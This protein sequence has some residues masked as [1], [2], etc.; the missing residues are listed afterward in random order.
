VRL[1]TE[2]VFLHETILHT[3]VLFHLRLQPHRRSNSRRT[4]TLP[5][6][7]HRRISP[8]T[9]LRNLHSPHHSN[10]PSRLA[11]VYLHRLSSP[12]KHPIPLLLHLHL[13]PTHMQISQPCSILPGRQRHSTDIIIH[14]TISN[15]RLSH[16]KTHTVACPLHPRSQIIIPIH[17][18]GLEG[19]HPHLLVIFMDN[20]DMGSRGHNFESSKSFW[21]WTVVYVYSLIKNWLS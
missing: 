3:Q 8:R 18:N 13:H 9:P 20:Q 21:S 19:S 6:T 1:S 14:I 7:E 5:R 16:H 2:L 11:S 15:N 12:C 17:L 10:N 4:H